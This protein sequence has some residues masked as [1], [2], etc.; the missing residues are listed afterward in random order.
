MLLGKNY[1]SAFLF[2]RVITQNIV[3]FP[4]VVC[5]NVIS[6]DVMIVTSLRSDGII[7]GINFLNKMSPQGGS[8]QKLRNCV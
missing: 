5:D 4:E 7:L 2:S 6:N 3:S 1:D 8:C